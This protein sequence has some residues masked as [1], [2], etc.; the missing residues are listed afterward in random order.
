MFLR[1][2]LVTAG[3]AAIFGAICAE[4]AAC[5]SGTS[6]VPPAGDSGE[7]A[8]APAPVPVTLPTCTT[9]GLTIAFNPMYSAYDGKHIFQVPALVVGSNSPVT[10][11]ADTSMVEMQADSERPNEILIQ[12]VRAGKTTI[13]AQSS[14]GKCATAPLTITA[15]KESDWEIG[16]ARYNDGTS[17]HLNAAPKGGSGSVLEPGNGMPGPACTNCHGETATGS[18]FTDVSHTPEQTGGFR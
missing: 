1:K 10:W 7:A 4:L 9:G 14:D 12:V 8:E 2:P 3:I 17:L 18:E 6:A 13:V 11:S 5:S 15:V 16:N